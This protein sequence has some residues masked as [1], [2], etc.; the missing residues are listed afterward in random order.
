MPGR[1]R[2]SGRAVTPREAK[3]GDKSGPRQLGDRETVLLDSI[4]LVVLFVRDLASPR[5]VEAPARR[6]GQDCAASH[7]G[8]GR[9]LMAVAR[10][11]IASATRSSTPSASGAPTPATR[12]SDPLS[13]SRKMLLP[14]L[15][16]SRP[17]CAT[18]LVASSMLDIDWSITTASWSERTSSVRKRRA[19]SASRMRVMSWT[20]V[21]APRM[22]PL[23]M[24]GAVDSTI[25]PLVPSNRSMSTTTSAKDCPFFERLGRRPVLGAAG[26][27]PS[28]ARTRRTTRTRRSSAPPPRRPRSCGGR[29]C[30]AAP[31]RPR[32]RCPG[33]PGPPRRWRAAAPPPTSAPA[34]PASARRC[35]GRWPPCP[36]PGRPSS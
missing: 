2:L 34:A 1:L 20:I 15:P 26:A 28:R 4:E 6:P 11:P 29:R 8:G 21:T 32:P 23:S 22:T 5:R 18:T 3:R 12:R 27:C 24:I 17:A 30:G 10:S 19:C 36:P 35:R 9:G 13:P 25:V 14:S 31:R 7:A 33:P 16:S